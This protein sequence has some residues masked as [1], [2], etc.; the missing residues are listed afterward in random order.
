M[1]CRAIYLFKLVIIQPNKIGGNRFRFKKQ[2]GRRDMQPGLYLL[3]VI[4]VF[5]VESEAHAKQ[6]VEFGII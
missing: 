2:P 1:T 6:Q 3:N 4:L 5:M